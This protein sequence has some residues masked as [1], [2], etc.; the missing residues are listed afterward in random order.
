ML[1]NMVTRL[2]IH[3]FFLLISLTDLQPSLFAVL[4]N[5]LK[6]AHKALSDV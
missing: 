2:L 6:A 5:N 1:I 4:A 3:Y